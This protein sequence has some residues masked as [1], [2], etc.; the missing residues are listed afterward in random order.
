MI[1]VCGFLKKVAG[2]MKNQEILASCSTLF[3]AP[4]ASFFTFICNTRGKN[5]NKRNSF[6]TGFQKGWLTH[7]M[8]R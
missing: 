4:S 6:T 8:L 1:R 7:F 5:P 2:V 3:W